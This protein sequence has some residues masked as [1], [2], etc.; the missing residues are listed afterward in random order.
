M[1]GEAFGERLADLH[2]IYT[3]A[4]SYSVDVVAYVCDFLNGASM[5]ATQFRLSI[6]EPNLVAITFLTNRRNGA[7]KCNEGLVR[8]N[9]V[10]PTGI[11]IL[12]IYQLIVL[13]QTISKG[14]KRVALFK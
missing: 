9:F 6:N 12:L 5:T 7:C 4:G 1:K 2:N 10:K 13:Y 14:I 3:V 11:E 8:R